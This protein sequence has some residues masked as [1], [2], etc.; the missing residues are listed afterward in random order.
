MFCYSYCT[1]YELGILP[2]TENLAS[3]TIRVFFIPI[4]FVV[5]FAMSLTGLTKKEKK[6]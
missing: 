5:Y 3:T 6:T 2:W 1:N 4:P